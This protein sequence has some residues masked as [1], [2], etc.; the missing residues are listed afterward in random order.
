MYI[1]YI[2]ACVCVWCWRNERVDSVDLAAFESFASACQTVTSMGPGWLGHDFHSCHRPSHAPV[3]RRGPALCLGRMGAGHPKDF[4]MDERC[5]GSMVHGCMKY[6]KRICVML[7]L[8]NCVCGGWYHQTETNTK[9]HLTHASMRELVAVGWSSGSMAHQQHFWVPCVRL[10]EWTA[11]R[12]VASWRMLIWVCGR[13]PPKPNGS[14][15]DSIRVLH[16]GFKI[17]WIHMIDTVDLPESLQLPKKYLQITKWLWTSTETLRV[18]KW[19]QNGSNAPSSR[20]TLWKV[21]T[22]SA[23]KQPMACQF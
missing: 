17:L 19:V 16:G 9:H 15:C 2:Y 1:I 22:E 3:S 6:V 8:C 20:V 13:D 23:V 18:R 5:M 11:S 7:L 10:T 21:P 4:F 12:L 14:Q